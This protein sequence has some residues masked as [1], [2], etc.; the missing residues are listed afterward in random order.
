MTLQSIFFEAKAISLVVISVTFAL[1]VVYALWPSSQ[2]RFDEAAR[3]P[4]SED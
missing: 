3:M 2:A 1:I 4:L